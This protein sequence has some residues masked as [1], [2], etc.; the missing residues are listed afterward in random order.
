[1]SQVETPANGTKRAMSG[2]QRVFY[3]GYWVKAYDTPADTLTAKK[4]LIEALTRRL[5][6]HVE[7]GV[8]IPGTR[9]EEAQVSP[10]CSAAATSSVTSPGRAS[11]CRRARPSSSSERDGTGN[12][13]ALRPTEWWQEPSVRSAN[14][15]HRVHVPLSISTGRLEA[16]TG[17]GGY[18]MV[19]MIAL[20]ALAW[21]F[22]VSC[23]AVAWVGFAARPATSMPAFIISAGSR[24]HC[25]VRLIDRRSHDVADD[26]QTRK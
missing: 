16:V 15:Q 12:L 22:A 11:R 26:F 7:H 5:F 9:L 4:R 8:N 20:S 2:Q 10:C 17:S 1:M 21:A 19:L 14:D 23:V 25:P 13:G 18:A 24:I 6:N 3:D